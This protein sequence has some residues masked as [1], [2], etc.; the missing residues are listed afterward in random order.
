M[1]QICKYLDSG[2][3]ELKNKNELRKKRRSE[4]K[5]LSQTEEEISDEKAEEIIDKHIKVR[6]EE[7]QV[8]IEFHNE[9]KKI[10][11]PKKVMQLYMVEI[12]FREHLLRM[13]RDDQVNRKKTQKKELP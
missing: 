8:D 4:W 7:L 12:Q 6:K 11:S 9:L 3:T 2:I 5:E 1:I 10:L 13:I